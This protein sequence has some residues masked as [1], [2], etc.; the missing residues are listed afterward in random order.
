M[1]KIGDKMENTGE[2]EKHD[3]YIIIKFASVA[4]VALQLNVENCTPLQLLA[5]ANYLELKGKNALLLEENARAQ[6]E[7]Q[8]NLAI[9][10]GA[11][12]IV[13]ASGR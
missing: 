5:A 7:A 11:N 1:A 8:Q 2:T 6:R 13:V 12:K 9:P 4:S 3:S 10:E